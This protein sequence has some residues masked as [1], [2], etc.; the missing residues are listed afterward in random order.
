MYNGNGRPLSKKKQ[1][2]VMI[3]LTI[4][5]WATQTL[6][7]QWGFGA[8][9]QLT[10]PNSNSTD[11]A[12]ADATSAASEDGT[13][14]KETFVPDDSRAETGATLE[15]RSEATI[16]GTE[17]KLKQI[18]RW[19]DADKPVFAPI[20]DFVVARIKPGS[21]FRSV[22]IAQIKSM[23]HDAGINLATI[24]VVGATACTIARSDT[25]YDERTALE[26]WIDAKQGTGDAP[27]TQPAT[28]STPQPNSQPNAQPSP[29]NPWSDSAVQGVSVTTAPQAQAAAQP[30]VLASET[31]EKQ[32]HS[33]RELLTRDLAT[34]TNLPIDQLQM[35]F[36]TEDEKVLNLS[37]P[38]F[39][40]QIDPLRVRNLGD[41]SWNVTIFSAGESHRISINAEGRAWQQQLV[42]TRPLDSR[43]VI[44]PDDYVE[45][46]TLVDSLPNEPLLTRDQL[47]NEQAAQSL[48][49]GTIMTSRMVDAVPLVKA[50]QFVTVTVTQGGVQIKTVAQA[51]EAG[52]YGQTIRAKNEETRD[53]FEVTMTGPQAATMNAT[54]SPDS[55]PSR[56]AAAQ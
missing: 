40:F 35:N 1:V 49:P 43:Q 22:S 41:V 16:I 33:L 30:A 12:P 6:R 54:T 45:R 7:H 32:F 44:Q 15:L 13:T 46:R 53:I 3:A 37:E 25:V 48:K 39:R 52:S 20:A 17:I 55:T 31:E 24:N 5:A 27:A 56:M 50:G 47:I 18:C 9:V 10:T 4:L 19:A 8:D 34:R 51:M 23:L 14:A 36:R 38:T 11:A 28:D 21:P 29:P 26:Q 42:L 2:H